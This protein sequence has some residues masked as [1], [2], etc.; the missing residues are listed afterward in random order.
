MKIEARSS[1]P[2]LWAIVA[3]FVLLLAT[4]SLPVQARVG[5]QR[6]GI[7]SAE[8]GNPLNDTTPPKVNITQPKDGSKVMDLIVVCVN[9]TDDTGVAYVEFR[10][11]STLKFNTS[12]APYNW[13]WFTR[14][15][16]NGTHVINATAYDAAGNFN[17]SKIS[18]IVDNDYLPPSVSIVSP[19]DGAIITSDVQIVVN[20]SDDHGNVS[21]VVFNVDGKIRHVNNSPKGPYNWLWNATKEKNG[22]HTINVTAYDRWDHNASDQISVTVQVKDVIAPVVKMDSPTAGAEVFDVIVVKFTA[23]DN[24]ALKKVELFIDFISKYVDNKGKNG[25]Y[26]WTWDTSSFSNGV[27]VLNASA[28]DTSGNTAW[29]SIIVSVANLPPP[30][31]T[32]PQSEDTVMGNVQIKGTTTSI[33]ITAV[34]VKIDNA[35]WITAN[36]TAAWDI[37]WNTTKVKNGQHNISVRASNGQRNSATVTI[38]VY[39]DNPPLE[40][41]IT[42]PKQNDVVSGEVKISG[43]ASTGTSWVEVRLD[44]SNWTKAAGNTSWSVIWD[45][46]DEPNGNHTIDARAYNGVLMNYTPIVSVR[47]KVSN[48]RTGLDPQ[49]AGGIVALLAIILIF[50]FLYTLGKRRPAYKEEEERFEEEGPEEEEEE[51]EKEEKEEKGSDK[52]PEKKVA[53]KKKVKDVEKL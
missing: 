4:A 25:T 37:W 23:E 31:V 28:E 50:I 52:E 47:V 42:A 51:Q 49:V 18:V 3:L 7:A 40:C 46:K 39:V 6:D 13:T 9:A 19:K 10:V 30:Q 14:D 44:G 8:H 32:S 29:D 12:T 34:Q 5:P 21:K 16:P 2:R 36:G 53:T 22:Q 41:A 24:V 26:N 33:L 48:E 20:A 27:H 43:T 17:W 11:D 35:N 38:K 45:T 1:G 15:T